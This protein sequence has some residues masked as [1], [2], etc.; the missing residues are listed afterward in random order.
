MEKS[1]VVRPPCLTMCFIT[2]VGKFLLP[3]HCPIF[4]SLAPIKKQEKNKILYYEHIKH[5]PAEFQTQVSRA[6]ETTKPLFPF[7][8][9]LT[10]IPGL[11]YSDLRTKWFLSSQYNESMLPESM[12]V[13]NWWASLETTGKAKRSGVCCSGG[14]R[15]SL[16]VKP[17]PSSMHLHVSPPPAAFWSPQSLLKL[18]KETRNTTETQQAGLGY[19]WFLKYTSCIREKVSAPGRPYFI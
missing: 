8:H 14:G 12:E 11:V 1:P 6:P 2:K 19:L 3:Q 13:S 9:L 7:C 15:T 4:F 16:L 18:N 5:C 10:L 17:L